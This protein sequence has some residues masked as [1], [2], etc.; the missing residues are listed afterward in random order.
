MF[1]TLYI[2]ALSSTLQ[3]GKSGS[4]SAIAVS[5]PA[6][7]LTRMAWLNRVAAQAAYLSGQVL[8]E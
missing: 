7:C 5:Y 6:R 4:V 3:V 2:H 1:Y 8:P